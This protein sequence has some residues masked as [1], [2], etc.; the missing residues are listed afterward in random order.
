MAKLDKVSHT[1]LR[2]HIHNIM[3]NYIAVHFIR[4]LVYREYK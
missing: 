4:L 3:Q 2:N 1:P